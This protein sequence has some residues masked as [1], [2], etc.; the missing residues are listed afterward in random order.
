MAM[1]VAPEFNLYFTHE[2]NVLPK[3]TIPVRKSSN[4]SVGNKENETEVITGT[5]GESKTGEE[6]MVKTDGPSPVV[7]AGE[8]DVGINCG[9][10]GIYV[11]YC[12]HLFDAYYQRFVVL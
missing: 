4:G 1:F 12:Q 6:E 3:S 10:C 7:Q 8:T 11:L 2:F 9:C 5:G